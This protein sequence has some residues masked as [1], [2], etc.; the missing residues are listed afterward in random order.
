MN[1]A[2]LELRLQANPKS[3]LFARLAFCYLSE[4][5]TEKA[6]ATCLAGLKNFPEY[7]TGHLVLGQCYETSGRDMEALLEYRSVLRAVPD[8]P[9]VRSLAEKIEKREQE[10]FQAFAEE[11]VKAMK[12]KRGTLSL[13]K[14]MSGTDRPNAGPPPGAPELQA[15]SASQGISIVTPTL[16]EIYASQGEFEEAIQAY[17]R[18]LKERPEQSAK[19]SKR[20]GE[21]EREYRAKQAETES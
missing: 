6:I 5:Q 20:I 1:T 18:L 11:R 10:A 19:F 21:L 3:P 4:G 12:E 7:T 17:K 15:K 14:F 2:T 9:R 13:E 16:A 8:N